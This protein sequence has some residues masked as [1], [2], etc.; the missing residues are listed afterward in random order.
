MQGNHGYPRSQ[1][2]IFTGVRR[3]TV[4]KVPTGL[5]LEYSERP[6]EGENVPSRP[7]EARHTGDQE[8]SAYFPD[9]LS[10]ETVWKL[11]AGRDGGLRSALWRAK[12][13]PRICP[14]TNGVASAHI[15]PSPQDKDAPASTA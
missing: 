8:P 13:T 3:E 15:F 11:L 9:S 6:K 4:W 10:R 1:G 7:L 5:D 14:T 2:G 12:D